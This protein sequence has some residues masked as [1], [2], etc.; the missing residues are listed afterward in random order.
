M[1][2]IDIRTFFFFTFDVS[3]V[4]GVYFNFFLSV[5]LFF[6]FDI[7]ECFSFFFFHYLIDIDESHRLTFENT[8][9]FLFNEF[10]LLNFIQKF[11]F[12]YSFK[13]YKPVYLFR[14]VLNDFLLSLKFLFY[15]FFFFDFFKFF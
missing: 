5:F 11:Y 13:E 1:F 8:K 6:A 3:Y 4:L 9:N 12:F 7:I 10:M 15:L 14:F 2:F